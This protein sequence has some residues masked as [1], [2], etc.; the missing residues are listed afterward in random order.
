MSAVT[1]RWLR[2]AVGM[3]AMAGVLAAPISVVHAQDGGGEQINILRDTEIEAI[4]HQEMD[5]IIYT[6]TISMY[7]P[8]ELP[9]IT[10]QSP[11]VEPLSPYTSS[12]RE[13]ELVVR[14]FQAEGRPVT[15]V[16]LRTPVSGAHASAGHPWPPP[17]VPPPSR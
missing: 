12:K 2:A 7:L 11:L 8:S 13:A 4:L 16:V 5:P 1:V 6:S 3:V 10:P 14:E 17:A 9:V 15:S